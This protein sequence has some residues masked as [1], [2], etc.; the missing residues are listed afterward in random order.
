MSELDAFETRF[1][2]AYRR[3]L[4]EVP[5]EVDAAAVVRTVTAAHPGPRA[6]AWSWSLRPA[7]ALAWLVLL[8]LL[9]AAL[10]AATFLI[11]SQPVQ[12]LPAVIPPV[13][14]TATPLTAYTTVSEGP[15]VAAS[16]NGNHTCAIRMDGTLECWG[17]N[18]YGEATGQSTPPDGTYIAVSASARGHTCAIRTNGTLACWGWNPYGQATPPSGTYLAVSAGWHHT[19]AIRT[20]GTLECWGDNG[21]GQSTP[22][23]GTYRAVGAGSWHTCAIRT[24]GALTCWGLD[25]GRLNT[26]A[27]T[28][29]F[30]DAFSQCA[31][32]TDG[33]LAC[34]PSGIDE[35]TPPPGTYVAVN[36]EWSRR[37]AL[38]TDGT[39][40]CWG[41]EASPPPTGTFTA[42]TGD[43]PDWEA[44]AIRTDGKLTCWGV[45]WI[46][47]TK[48]GSPYFSPPTTL[49]PE[50][51]RI[52]LAS[53]LPA[54]RRGTV[55]FGSGGSG[56]SVIMPATTFSV[57]AIHF[58][59]NL[60]R[61]VRAGETVTVTLSV[62]G[63]LL[64][65]PASRTF[66][67]QGDCVDGLLYWAYAAPPWSDL[68]AFPISW[69]TGHY[70][71]NLSA[72]GK[73]LAEG[74]FDVGP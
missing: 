62:D 32:R 17:S 28:Y 2:A 38:G 29:V 65:E 12:R 4:D 36:G 41:P 69:T 18:W 57:R 67:V 7:P 54:I 66:D 15:Y 22:P 23:S 56:C 73:V 39:L 59:A 37:C 30:V 19:C 6:G 33:T 27:G 42:L 49:T 3:Y 53:E 61:E 46:A 13:T 24:D 51:R 21:D 35:P 74:E 45:D 60:E 63:D 48:P 1:A 11:G 5:T 43:L 8:A 52:L 31:I 71:L 72:G 34:W 16:A 20:D 47:K 40:T 10:G 9:L 70:R 25:D 58:A 50:L 44:C 68:S 64:G 14:P 55:E 26:P